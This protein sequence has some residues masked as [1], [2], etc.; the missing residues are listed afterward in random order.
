VVD[1]LTSKFV[2]KTIKIRFKSRV[3]KTEDAD[4]I[5]I[6][7]FD[8]RIEGRCHSVSSVLNRIDRK[9]TSVKSEFL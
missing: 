7:D 8:I 2:Q 4:Y 3:A 5:V 9:H 1:H 6:V